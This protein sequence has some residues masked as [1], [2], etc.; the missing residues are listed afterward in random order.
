[1]NKLYKNKIYKL[2]LNDNRIKYFM[3]SDE[4]DIENTL[5]YFTNKTINE[6]DKYECYDYDDNRFILYVINYDEGIIVEYDYYNT[7]IKTYYNKLSN[8]EPITNIN[9]N[10]NNEIKYHYYLQFCNNISQKNLIK[11]YL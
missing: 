9:Y 2:E 1:M 8:Y 4:Q 3:L 5:S 7:E 10:L 11:K 6:V